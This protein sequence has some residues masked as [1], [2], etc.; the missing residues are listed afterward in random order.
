MLG[1]GAQLAAADAL[2]A[3]WWLEE[4]QAVDACQLVLAIKVY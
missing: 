2:A 3:R 4:R 1:G